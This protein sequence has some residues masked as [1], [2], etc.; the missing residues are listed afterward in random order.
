[1]A[2]VDANTVVSTDLTAARTIDFV[3]RFVNDINGITAL[4]GDVVKSKRAAGT[5]IVVKRAN[6]TLNNTAVG[7]GEL[8][9]YNEVEYEEE[10]VGV[11]TFD[12]QKIGVS[13]EAVAKHGYDAAVQSADNDMIFKLENKIIN[14]FITFLGTGELEAS[15]A[16]F[17]AALA[18]ANGQVR[19]YFDSIGK[20]ISG[21][22]G[23]CN[24]LDA[25]RYLGTANITVQSQFGMDYIENFLGYSKL[26]LSSRVPTGKIYAT[27]SENIRLDYLDPSDSDFTKA[28]FEFTTDGILNLI[29]VH[30]GGNYGTV[31]SETTAVT[32]TTLYADYIDGVA[33]VTIGGTNP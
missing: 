14:N 20:G 27:P 6:V 28:G 5:N 32:G 8:V 24:T 31:V 23:F 22:I 17:Q 16:D 18:E 21:V 1:M 13:F 2:A 19:N 30:I 9:P 25:Y 26:F 33:V 15:A 12:K 3:S 10:T 29:G 11:L 7:E 4:L